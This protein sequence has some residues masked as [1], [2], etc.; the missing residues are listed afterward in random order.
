MVAV[1]S[2][3]RNLNVAGVFL[4]GQKALRQRRA[5]IGQN[6]F[7][8]DNGQPSLFAALG[9]ELFR[10]ITSHHAPARNSDGKCPHCFGLETVLRERLTMNA[11]SS[12]Q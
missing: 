5:L 2:G 10:G 6:I 12:W 9:D 1:K 7:R 11:V 3:I 8:R 4:A